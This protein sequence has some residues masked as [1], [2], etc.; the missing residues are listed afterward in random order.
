VPADVVACDEHG[1]GALE[2][3]VDHGRDASPGEAANVAAPA[4]ERHPTS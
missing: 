2:D 1:I 3:P 4:E